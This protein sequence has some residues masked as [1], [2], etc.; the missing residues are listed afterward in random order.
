MKAGFT[1]NSVEA[2]R[3]NHAHIHLR[4]RVRKSGDTAANAAS[5]C[6]HYVCYVR[7]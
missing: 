4:K 2:I 6:E 5:V 3:Q 7:T 1:M